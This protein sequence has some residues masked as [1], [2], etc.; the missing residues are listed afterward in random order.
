VI[1]PKNPAGHNYP[2]PRSSS[3]QP[4]SCSAAANP[5]S[6][7]SRDG[8]DKVVSAGLFS[9]L[10]WSKNN[11]FYIADDRAGNLSMFKIFLNNNWP[12]LLE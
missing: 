8:D 7:Q 1:S 3:P 11:C 12:K 4:T 5:P 2:T 10:T 9:L 6:H